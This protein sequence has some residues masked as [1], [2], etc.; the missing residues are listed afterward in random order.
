VGRHLN[1]ETLHFVVFGKAFDFHPLNLL[2]FL[3]VPVERLYS[4]IGV[5]IHQKAWF[6]SST[7][8]SKTKDKF[9]QRR[10]CLATF[11]HTSRGVILSPRR[12]RLNLVVRELLTVISKVSEGV[13]DLDNQQTLTV[14]EL[15]HKVFHML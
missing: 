1:P 8:P 14:I 6:L 9:S 15:R 5:L 11:S 13:I 10:T 2:E 3:C 4:L 12:Y 7:V